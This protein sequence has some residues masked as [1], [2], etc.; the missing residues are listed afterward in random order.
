M[1][2]CVRCKIK[3]KA[4]YII[5]SGDHVSE[6]CLQCYHS[7][8]NRTF[9]C[10]EC[11]NPSNPI[12]NYTLT[13]APYTIT[14][15]LCSAVCYDREVSRREIS[16]QMGYPLYELCGHC[17]SYCRRKKLRC[18]HCHLIQYCS[19]ECYMCDLPHHQVVCTSQ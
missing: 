10:C 5:R 18:N 14:L 4:Y 6:L 3:L 12:N 19:H 17:K 13:R 15:K 7:M 1:S 8:V 11:G 16:E 9:T 2:R